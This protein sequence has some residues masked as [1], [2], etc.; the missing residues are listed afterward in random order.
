MPRVVIILILLVVLVNVVAT[1]YGDSSKLS[2]EGVKA[3][4][5]DI[6]NFITKNSAKAHPSQLQSHWL[7]LGILYQVCLT[8][9]F[10]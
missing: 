10:A 4:I 3:Q 2:R 7:Q 9:L 6:E 5:E 8:L 1:N